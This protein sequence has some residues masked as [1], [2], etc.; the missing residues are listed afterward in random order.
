[1]FQNY[2]KIA[3]RHISR[4][5]GYVFINVIGLGVALA[6]S[7][8]A[9]VNWQQGQTADKN[10]ENLDELYQV[11]VQVVGMEYPTADVSAPLVARA[12]N[13]VSGIKAGIR[14]ANKGVT[15]K[16]GTN[17]FKERLSVAD[18]NFLESFT[19][20]LLEGDKNAIKDPSKIYISADKAKKYFGTDNPRT[21]RIDHCWCFC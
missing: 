16:R 12:A 13:D 4:N 18:D 11:I 15:I 7:I 8:I 20:P 19:F 9:F 3:L 10:H 17:V 1:M 2:L 21:K 5:K 14:W 6:I